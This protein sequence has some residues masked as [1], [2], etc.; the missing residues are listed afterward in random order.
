MD[1]TQQIF[2]AVRAGDTGQVQTLLA[3]QPNL[4]NAK[5]ERGHSPVLI[6]QYHHKRDVVTVLLAAGPELDLFD[7]ASV[8]RTERVAELLE[9]DPTQVNAY[10]SDGFYPLGLAAFFA[11]PDTVRELLARGADVT[12][13]ARNPM[14]IQPLHAA[15]AGKSMDVVRLLVEAGAPV[16]V[17]QQNG[18]TPLHA[19][20]Q[21]KDLE[22]TRYLVAHG[23]DPKAQNDEG[24]SAIGMAA[25][26]GSIDIL[27]VLK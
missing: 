20:V 24:K 2:D 5:N 6:A 19:A 16:N 15:T 12:Q 26:Q 22:M 8:G 11:Q 27:K 1:A 18:W 23:A 13:V 7:A 4:V 21:H 17:K 3:A 9:R 10:S 25:E 14:R